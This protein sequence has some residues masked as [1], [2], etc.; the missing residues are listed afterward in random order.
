[1]A[2][3]FLQGKSHRSKWMMTRGTPMTYETSKMFC[4]K[5]LGASRSILLHS[6]LGALRATG[7]ENQSKFGNMALPSKQKCLGDT[8]SSKQ[9]T[10]IWGCSNNL[11]SGDLTV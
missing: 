7:P 6:Q 10:E 2:G 9:K 1:M 11:P 8:T 3:W 5:T 4:L